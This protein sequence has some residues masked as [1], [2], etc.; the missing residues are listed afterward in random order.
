MIELGTGIDP[1]LN[2][3]VHALAAR[4][5]HAGLPGIA[6][7]V[8]AYAS[9]CLHYDPLAWDYATLVE[10]LRPLLEAEAGAPCPGRELTVPVCYG[11]EFGPDLAALATHCGLSESEVIARHSAGAY[12]VY[13]LGFAP[14]FPYL[15]GL[16]PALAMP[17]RAQPRPRV[18]AGSVA[19]GGAQ[20][21]IYPQ[22]TPGG[23]QL[24]GRTPWRLFD[25]A[26]QPPCRI[27]PG[28]R[29]R[30]RAI[31]LEEFQALAEQEDRA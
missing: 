21:G 15:G 31:G 2:A 28:D 20:T 1:G 13:F 4:L 18:P 12:P 14:G 30:F 5:D 3:R 6:D 7:R 29:L 23:W 27:L 16:D 11:G 25:P 22:A 10:R 26:R 24:V 8:P 19:I 9:L 17:R